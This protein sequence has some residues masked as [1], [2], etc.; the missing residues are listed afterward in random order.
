[1][2][3]RKNAPQKHTF[4]SPSWIRA[5]H[6]LRAE[7]D[8]RVDAPSIAVRANLVVT[9]APFA[10]EVHGH[11]DTSSGGLTIETGHLA[12]VDLTI[13]TDYTTAYTLFV[14]QDPAAVMQAV[15]AGKVRVVG[16]MTKLLALQLPLTEP[17]TAAVAEEIA[18]RIRDFTE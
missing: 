6:A 9:A 10:A 13:T 16:D 1:M 2:P 4:L 5:V 18:G 17:R 11:F 14:G 15:F 7:Y 8:D 3:A 12:A